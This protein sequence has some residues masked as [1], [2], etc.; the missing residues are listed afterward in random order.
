MLISQ[1]YKAV[2]MQQT[3]VFFLKKVKREISM[4]E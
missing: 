2:G 1:T 3:K 4:I